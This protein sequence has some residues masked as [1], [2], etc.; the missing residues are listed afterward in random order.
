MAITVVEVLRVANSV[1]A[2]G[3]GF[4]SINTGSPLSH[5]PPQKVSPSPASLVGGGAGDVVVVVVVAVAVIETLYAGVFHF[6]VDG[7]ARRR[8][9][10]AAGQAGGS[11]PIGGRI[12]MDLTLYI[13]ISM[14]RRAQSSNS[15]FLVFSSNQNFEILN[16]LCTPNN[17]VCS[18]PKSD[19]L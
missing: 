2:E 4:G 15:F 1:I 13:K 16:P 8:R 14:I 9:H 3:Q 18:L 19:Y 17:G 5:Q 10:H 11:W 7:E 6:V 12:P